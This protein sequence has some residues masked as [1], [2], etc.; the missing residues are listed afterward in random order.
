[1]L[2]PQL[3]APGP[4]VIGAPTPD[5]WWQGKNVG[6]QPQNS[7]PCPKQGENIPYSGLGR[8]SKAPY[9]KC[10]PSH[11]KGKRVVCQGRLVIGGAFAHPFPSSCYRVQDAVQTCLMFNLLSVS[12]EC[13]SF[14]LF[15][16]NFI[17][18]S[19]LQTTTL[20]RCS[21]TCS[22][23]FLWT[24]KSYYLIISLVLYGASCAW[25]VLIGSLQTRLPSGK[26]IFLR[27]IQLR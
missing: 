15:I 12:P 23:A 10:V 1:M 26:Y 3:S 4:P 16:F 20:P 25:L 8:N 14:T 5:A 27:C 19:R 18:C 13:V 21:A 11:R 9:E 22:A 7:C 2:A 17:W 6:V 24:L